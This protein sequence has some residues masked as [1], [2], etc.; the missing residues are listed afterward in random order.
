MFMF[1][2]LFGSLPSLFHKLEALK[3]VAFILHSSF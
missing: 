1:I 3:C 2:L